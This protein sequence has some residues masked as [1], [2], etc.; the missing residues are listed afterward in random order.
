[1]VG[2]G[3]LRPDLSIARKD[4]PK[5]LI[6]FTEDCIKFNRDERPLFRQVGAVLGTSLLDRS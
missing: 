5:A 2:H 1:M 4:T 3:L 6:R